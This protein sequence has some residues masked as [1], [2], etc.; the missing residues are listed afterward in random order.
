V[1]A[2]A[3]VL[4][5]PQQEALLFVEEKA[6]LPSRPRPASRSVARRCSRGG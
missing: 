1:M 6:V 2:H 5:Q 3:A 4:R